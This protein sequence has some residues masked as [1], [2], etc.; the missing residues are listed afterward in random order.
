MR[1]TLTALVLFTATLFIMDSL[2]HKERTIFVEVE[3]QGEPT[4]EWLQTTIADFERGDSNC[5]AITEVDDGEVV[6]AKVEDSRYCTEGTFVSEV[7]QSPVLFNIVAAGWSVD[8]PLGGTFHIQVRAGQD[9]EMWTDWMDVSPDEDG[10]GSESMTWGNLLEVPPSRYVQY[11]LVLGTF[12]PSTSPTVRTVLL[13][14]MD[15]RDGPTVEQARAMILPQEVTSGVPQPRIISRKGWG[16][17]ESWATREPIYRKPVAFVIHHT[18]TP[19]NPED[20]AY[21]VR[22]ILRYHALTRGWGDIGYNFLIDR[23]GNIYEGRKGGDGVVGIHAGDY[24]YGSIGIAL[25]GDYRSAEMTPAMKE[26]LVSLMAW[27]A[28]RYGIHP[29]ESSYFV[30]RV[31]PHIVGHRDLW[32]TV[33]PGDKVYKALPELRELTW[34][35]LLTRKPRVEIVS[36]EA[37]EAVSGRIVIEVSSP[38]P[39]TATTRLLLDGAV[40]AEGGSSLT[41]TWNTEAAAEGPHRIDAVATSVQGRRSRVVHEVMVDNTPPSGSVVVDDGARYATQMTVTLSLQA[42]DP[43]GS[44]VGM[45]F[46]QDNASEFTEAEEFASSREW[47][48]SP[49]DG[50]KT[51]G[52]RFLDWAGNASPVC[53]ATI[54]LDTAP[55]GNWGVLETE[56]SGRVVV[57]VSDL[58]SGLDLSS[59][60]Y[61]T[62][63][64]GGIT[65]S[66]WE[67]AVCNGEEAEESQSTSR[68]CAPS[69][70]GAVRFKVAD[71]AGNEG[72]SPIYG[73][74]VPPLPQD[75]PSVTA[76]P[77]SGPTATPSSGLPDLVVDRIA[78]APETGLN[79]G[80]LT[81]TVTI[82]NRAPVDAPNGFWVELFVDP[83]GVPTINSVAGQEGEGAFWYVPGLAAEETLSLALR[84]A[85][86]RYTS[87]AGNLT[88]GRHEIYAYVDAYNSV[89]ELGL[90][91]ELDETNNVLGPLI[92]DVGQGVNDDGSGST[93]SDLVGMLSSM[94]QQLE[95]LLAWLSDQVSSR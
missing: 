78:V 25:L 7:H 73:E 9:G 95:R 92:V 63:V 32:T 26:A 69:V 62:S 93:T 71:G 48:L 86:D 94:V 15:T 41:W 85:D 6:L 75:T 39:T 84:D 57:E 1:R 66:D 83:S 74:A 36:P 17:N 35:R 89:G 64:D 37:G 28:D 76:E 61:S 10:P 23:E 44:V 2:P 22:A 3:T 43:D 90:V 80:P 52:A 45:Q 65:W 16:A 5:V 12:E 49:G 4:E 77:T 53:S 82:E 40:K 72:Q 19:N 33:C 59:A 54:I 79:S 56:D 11:R 50:G 91:S 13:S 55:P 70:G 58:G 67:P 31:F 27:E 47:V 18:V 81:I 21:I 60:E 14:V 20:P 30:H 34:Q 51:V 68:L 87:F 42:E 24:N 29:L 38:S 8:K 46:T 88:S